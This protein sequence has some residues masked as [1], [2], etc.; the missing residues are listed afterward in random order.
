MIAAGL[1]IGAVA[2]YSAVRLLKRND[3]GKSQ[4]KVP[5]SV[6][7]KTVIVPESKSEEEQ[8]PALSLRSMLEQEDLLKVKMTENKYCLNPDY[9]I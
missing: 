5:I 4:E 1:L 9:L 6:E 3:D 2:I 8:P 7:K